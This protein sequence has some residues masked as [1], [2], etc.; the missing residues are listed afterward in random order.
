[1]LG[2]RHAFHAGNHADVLKHLVL[3]HALRSLQRKPA[4][5]CC[6]DTHAGAGSYDLSGRDA[7]KNAEYA[8]GID[9]LWRA[10]SLPEPC[11]PY[12]ECVRAANPGTPPALRYYP[13]SPALICTL[14]RPQDRA[15]LIERH[16][17][18]FARLAARFGHVSRV[19]TIEGDGYAELKGAVPPI[20]RRGLVLMDPSY[21]LKRDY[22]DAVTALADACTRWA[23]GVYL[24]WYPLVSRGET[25]RFLQ[26]VVAAGVRRVLRVEFA[27]KP[28]QAASGLW[29]S[30]MLIVNPPFGLDGVLSGLLPVLSDLLGASPGARSA[31]SWLVPE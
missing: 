9:R 30:G 23:T 16:P 7:Q 27:L 14:L 18:D 3:I 19:R 15:V 29:G 25:D 22:Q 28:P 20:E 21:E 6:I 17:A 31:V 24:L 26:R 4:A 13:G 11:G 2:Y 5:L 1:M 10:A 12:L 8:G